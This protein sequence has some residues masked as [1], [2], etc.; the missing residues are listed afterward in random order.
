MKVMR[1]VRIGV[2][3]GLAAAVPSAALA[4]SDDLAGPLSGPPVVGAPFSADAITTVQQ[5][6]GD[7][8]RI[9]RRGTARYYRDRAG[10]VRVE[11]VILGLEALNPNLAASS[12]VRITVF[13]D[14]TQRTVYTLDPESR[15]AIQG[16]RDLAGQSIGGGDT[17]S[18]P[19]G[20]ARFLVFHRSERLQ[21]RYGFDGNAVSE[22]P[23][24]TRRIAGIDAVGK[25]ITITIPVGLLGNDRPMEIVDERWS[26][27]N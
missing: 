24:G 5:I 8:T 26:P 22:M 15:T 9:D 12:Q 14:P 21:Q 6:L 16:P 27:P 3:V 4:Q 23:L 11:Q 2:C 10:R 25:R 1:V 19:L 17:F 13:P 18:V 7:G 20:W